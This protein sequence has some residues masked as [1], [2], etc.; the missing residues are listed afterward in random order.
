MSCKRLDIVALEI[1]PIYQDELLMDEAYH[2]NIPTARLSLLGL[3]RLY[4]FFLTTNLRKGNLQDKIC[5]FSII[6]LLKDVKLRGCAGINPKGEK[7]RAIELN[8]NISNISSAIST[9]C[10]EIVCKMTKSFNHATG[11]NAICS[12]CMCLLR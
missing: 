4:K 8:M 5:L 11:F 2:K 1:R 12:L 3:T 7:S 10:Q 6:D 9:L